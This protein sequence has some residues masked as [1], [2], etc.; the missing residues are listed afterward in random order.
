MHTDSTHRGLAMPSLFDGGAS[1]EPGNAR[2]VGRPP[3][4]STHSGRFPALGGGG[5]G[6]G[7]EAFL[8]MAGARGTATGRGRAAPAPVRG[9]PAPNLV[10]IG[11]TSSPHHER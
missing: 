8:G 5:R 6:V 11:T 2:P 3:G 7:V 4:R 10:Y 1:M 9:A